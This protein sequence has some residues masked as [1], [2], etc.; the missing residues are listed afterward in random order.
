MRIAVT[1]AS[2]M[3]GAYLCRA[4]L[5]AGAQVVGTVRDPNKAPFLTDMGVAVKNAELMDPQS[6]MQA[7]AGCDAV[8]SNAAL[9]TLGPRRWKSFRDANVQGTD[10][11]YGVL[12]EHGPKRVV[13]ISSWGVYRFAYTQA[14][15][16]N[17]PLL[18]GARKEGGG[19]RASKMLSEERARQHAERC[20]L[21]LTV[22]RPAGIYGARDKNLMPKVRTA[23]RL[24]I[25]PK[26]GLEMSLSYAGDIANAVVGALGNE[27]SVGEIYNLGGDD[28]PF[29]EFIKE[30]ARRDPKGRARFPLGLPSPLVWKL[31][32]EKAKADLGFT[33]R[34]FAQ[35]IE[36]TYALEA[37]PALW[38]QSAMQA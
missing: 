20:G 31:K 29:G 28:I 2:G 12:C 25:L 3:L 27:K 24:P 36:E 7:F 35:G 21:R 38:A 23:V 15:D 4:L 17:T 33:N 10:N 14:M 34:A 5:Q 19:Y 22:V 30:V 6:L 8:I 18:D 37:D 16:E 13:Q 1:G 26:V 9:Y 11:L 32:S